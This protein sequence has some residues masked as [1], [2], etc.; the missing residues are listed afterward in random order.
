VIRDISV[1]GISLGARRN[2]ARAGD[3]M[4]LRFHLPTDEADLQLD[5][6]ALVRNAT[7]PAPGSDLCTY[8]IE[9]DQL[10]PVERLA[11]QCYVYEHKEQTEAS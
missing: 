2:I 5:I 9:F 3:R 4:Q 7:D 6:S 1:N 8:G 11:L 10:Q